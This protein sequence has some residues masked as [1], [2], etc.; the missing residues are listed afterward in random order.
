MSRFARSGTMIGFLLLM[1][2]CS[3]DPLPSAAAK[4]RERLLVDL[5]GSHLELPGGSELHEVSTAGKGSHG[6]LASNRPVLVRRTYSFT[7]D[8]LT[9]CEA[10]VAQLTAAGWSAHGKCDISTPPAALRLSF[11]CTGFDVSGSIT[12][13]AEPYLEAK[14][15]TLSLAFEATYPSDEVDTDLTESCP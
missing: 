5:P 12:T 9:A 7:G 1:T 2:S 10:A 14:A 13:Y 6:A 8:A 11:R 15:D 3:I 4:H